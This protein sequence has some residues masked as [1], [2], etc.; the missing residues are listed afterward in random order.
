MPVP[1]LDPR[2]VGGVLRR[3]ATQSPDSVFLVCDDRRLTYAELLGASTEAARGLV[4]A[5]VTRGTHVG[6]LLPNGVEFAVTALA[7]MRIGAVLVP[8]ST[9]SSSAELRTL[10]DR[11]DTQV[12]VAAREARGRRLDDLLVEAVGVDLPVAA[13][14]LAPS[15]PTLRRVFLDGEVGADAAS[16]PAEMVAALEAGVRPA[17]PVVIVHTSGS[18][19]APKGVVHAHGAL[20]DHLEVLNDLREYAP[21]DVLFSNSPF[22]WIGGFAYTFLG[23]LVAGATVLCSQ[24]ADPARVLDMME[25]ERPTMCN[26]YPASATALAADPSFPGRDLGSMTRGNLYALMPPGSV[27]ADPALRTNMLGMTEGGSVVLTG[28]TDEAEH[29]Q[30]EARRGSFG[31]PTPDLEARVVDPRTG[32]GCA[33]GVPGELWLRG[34]AMMLGYY[35]V[36]RSRVFDADGWFR[37]GDLVHRDGDDH[38]YFHGRGDDLIKT[39]G[40]NVAPAEV[41]A[42]VLAATGLASIAFGVPDPDKGHVVALALLRGDGDPPAPDQTALRALLAPLLSSY[43]IPKVVR[44][45]DP[46]EVPIRSSGKVDLTALRSVFVDG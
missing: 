32:V 27:P 42:A 18:T 29:D 8:M 1:D 41:Q 7:A 14:L 21:S 30:P 38:W 5:G 36:E 2:T 25:R 37:T 45:L 26:G 39:A 31:R 34:P 16:V 15:V 24:E 46:T 10:I 33:L 35:G 11:S 19:S 3:R 28:T 9:L 13:P 20:L 40:A 23:T 17:D 44:V 22:F 12:L 4:A 6:L 43:K